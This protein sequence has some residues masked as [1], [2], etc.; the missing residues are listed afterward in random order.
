MAD[1]KAGNMD[2][3]SVLVEVS[4]AFDG[5]DE[6]LREVE[7]LK[8][9]L[10]S[11]SEIIQAPEEEPDEFDLVRKNIFRTGKNKVFEDCLGYWHSVSVSRNDDGRIVVQKFEKWLERSVDKV[12]SY[13][14]RDQFYKFFD[15]EL[16]SAYESEK[17]KAL[18][19]LRKS[20]TEE[21]DV[22]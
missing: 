19:E 21:E 5:R 7:R 20:E 12:P 3:Y 16:K 17:A 15:N 22:D 13:M 1:R 10:N 6:A 4:R 14:S 18:N 8:R 2:K 11:R 9:E